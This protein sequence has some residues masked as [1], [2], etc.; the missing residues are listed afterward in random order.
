MAARFEGDRRTSCRAEVL[1]L[2]FVVFA[3]AVLF[4]F[5]TVVLPVDVFSPVFSFPAMKYLPLSSSDI[6]SRRSAKPENPR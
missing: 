3:D 1:F 6:L 5:F 4:F 2:F